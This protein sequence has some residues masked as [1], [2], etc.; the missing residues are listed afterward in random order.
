MSF[1]C[2]YFSVM[3][4]WIAEWER[5]YAPLN[6]R[7]EIAK[8]QEWADANPKRRKKN[9][10]R[11][12]VGWLNKAHANVVVAQVNARMYARVGENRDLRATQEQLDE[13]NRIKA[14]YPE[15]A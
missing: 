3:P 6:V 7:Q 12:C 2:E 9:W 14:K 1:E 5:D 4:D 10:M 13:V 15:L 11:F 8:M